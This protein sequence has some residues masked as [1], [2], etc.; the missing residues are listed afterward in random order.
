MLLAGYHGAQ[1]EDQMPLIRRWIS[2]IKKPP[3]Q[4]RW[5]VP[6]ALAAFVKRP[7]AEA[8]IG[9]DKDFNNLCSFSPLILVRVPSTLNS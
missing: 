5:A 6:N 8:Q 2:P 4:K 9:A 7:Q 1:A 3:Q